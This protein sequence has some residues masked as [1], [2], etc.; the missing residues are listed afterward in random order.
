VRQKFIPL[1]LNPEKRETKVVSYLFP[2]PESNYHHIKPIFFL[3]LIPSFLAD[4]RGG[5]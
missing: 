5:M 2:F 4:K 1:K 3:F